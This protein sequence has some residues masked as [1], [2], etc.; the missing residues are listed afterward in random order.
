MPNFSQMK[1]QWQ[2]PPKCTKSCKTQGDFRSCVRLFLRLF[3]HFPPTFYALNWASETSN[4]P[5]QTKN[6]PSQALNLPSQASNQPS[7]TPL[8][9]PLRPQVGPLRPQ[10]SPLGPLISHPRP[11]VSYFWPQIGLIRP[12]IHPGTQERKSFFVPQDI[13]PFMAAALLPLTPIHNHGKQ[14]NGYRWPHIATCYLFAKFPI[15]TRRKMLN[16]SH[17]HEKNGFKT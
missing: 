5:S 10:I 12:Q 4:P 6:P 2:Q 7:L 3:V 8:I 15:T 11:K 14:G 16:A 9:S 17:F 13:V 1:V